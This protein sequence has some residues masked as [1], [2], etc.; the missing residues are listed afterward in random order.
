MLLAR[1]LPSV[2]DLVALALTRTDFISEIR[3]DPAHIR[4]HAADAIEAAAEN[5]TDANDGAAI[6]S[7]FLNFAT[8]CLIEAG[9]DILARADADADA[10]MRDAIDAGDM[11]R[12][13][14]PVGYASQRGA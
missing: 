10:A 13:G 9:H 14:A 4:W 6:P 11:D 5:W 7:D 3:G 1:I 12:D 2:A 8:D